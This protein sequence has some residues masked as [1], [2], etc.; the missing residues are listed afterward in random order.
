MDPALDPLAH[1]IEPEFNFLEEFIHVVFTG[2]SERAAVTFG[3]PES[4]N[5][6]RPSRI[7]GGKLSRTFWRVS[8][9]QGIVGRERIGRARASLVF[10]FDEGS[11]GSINIAI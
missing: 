9:V 8:S 10:I 11:L 7:T 4:K 5:A 1:T 6:A 2:Q 3:S